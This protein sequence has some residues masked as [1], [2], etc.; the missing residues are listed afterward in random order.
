MTDVAL[1]VGD[2]SHVAT[3]IDDE[4]VRQ[5]AETSGDRNPLHLDDTYA[6]NT[7]FDGRIAHGMLV[8]GTISKAIAELPTTGTVA[9]LGQ[10]LE[11]KGPV[12]IGAIVNATAEVTEDLGGGMYRLETR[13]Q[14]DGEEVIGGGATILV[15]EWPLTED[16]D[17]DE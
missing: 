14:A 9:Y 4:D 16:G 6:R 11:F 8:A 5:F 3:T 7:R 13:V 1:E 15:D 10:N 2:R 17:A 12:S